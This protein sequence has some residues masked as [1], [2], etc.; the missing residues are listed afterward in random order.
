MDDY[1]RSMRLATAELKETIA[2]SRH[3]LNRA[4]E[5]LDT[6]RLLA[7]PLIPAPSGR[8]RDQAVG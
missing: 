7:S 3:T 8:K 1:F 2:V 6:A 5:L 4:Y